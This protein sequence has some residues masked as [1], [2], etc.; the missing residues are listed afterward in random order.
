M[1][2][3]TKKVLKIALGITLPTTLIFASYFGAIAAVRYNRFVKPN[4][5]QKYETN[6][7]KFNSKIYELNEEAKKYFSIDQNIIQSR[8]KDSILNEK[9]NVNEYKF[10]FDRKFVNCKNFN[11]VVPYLNF[12]DKLFNDIFKDLLNKNRKLSIFNNVI[13]T[14]NKR[15]SSVITTVDFKNDFLTIS[16]E[17]NRDIEISLN[18]NFKTNKGELTI[19]NKSKTINVNAKFNVYL[20]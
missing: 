14:I 6:E 1:T 5:P 3:R 9:N 2:I 10:M 15:N 4:L 20:R 18:V 8:E 11:Y 7:Y 19:T 17:I 13:S 16:K 12:N